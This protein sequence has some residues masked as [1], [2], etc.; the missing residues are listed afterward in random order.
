M[1][2]IPENVDNGGYKVVPEDG[3]NVS[4]SLVHSGARAI[5]FCDS[6]YRISPSDVT[7]ITCIDG[8]WSDVAPLCQL[9]TPAEYC[10]AV[11]V[12]EHAHHYEVSGSVGPDGTVSSGTKVIYVC[13]TGYRQL[14]WSTAM[15]VDGEWSSH[16]PTCIF[17]VSCSESP[18]T[19]PHSE[20][21][22]YRRDGVNSLLDTVSGGAPNGAYAY[23]YCHTGYRMTNANHSALV[24][25][26]GQWKGNVPTCGTSF[27]LSFVSVLWLERWTRN[28]EGSVLTICTVT[29]Q[30]THARCL[31]K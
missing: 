28:Q 15:C 2:A 3:I 16:G 14:G 11:L 9:R 8:W 31:C 19:V 29:G 17:D 10:T 6:G 7:A 13:D 23:Y 1:C 22:I 12:V 20:F 30:A 27:A 26:D 21:G 24:C 18:P 25:T 4:S 5:Y